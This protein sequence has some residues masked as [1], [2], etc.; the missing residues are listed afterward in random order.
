MRLRTRIGRGGDYP[1]TKSP[2]HIPAK[3][4]L[5]DAMV[6][7]VCRVVGVFATPWLR[8]P[9]GTWHMPRRIVVLKPCCMGDV[10]FTTP[11]L[12][13]IKAAYPASHLTVATSAWCA[14]VVVDNPHVDAVMDVPPQ[15]GVRDLRRVAALLREGGYDTALVPDRSPL[16]GVIV[17]LAGIPRRVGLNSDGRG[18]LYTDRVPVPPDGT[19]H[20]AAL[21]SRLGTAIGAPPL[22]GRGTEYRPPTDD[23]AAMDARIAAAGWQSPLWIIHPGGGVNPGT[24]FPPKRWLPDRFAA[25]A[26]GLLRDHGGTVLL[27]G[28]LTDAD[29][30]AAVRA[31]MHGAAVDLTDTLLFGAWQ[32]LAHRADLY[33]GND[34]GMTHLALAG[35]TPTVA[36]FGPTSSI[37]YGLYGENGMMAVGRVPWSPCWRNGSLACT[38]GTIQCMR[39]VPVSAVRAAADRLWGVAG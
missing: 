6:G 27:L 26:D 18:M 28:T 31:A 16:L 11:L 14:S 2:L 20:E 15:I 29:A 37:Q 9:R 3:Q 32:A 8:P 35:G 19:M 39:S 34:T 4:R 7:A 5:R 12:A 1:A 24:A 17:A 33:I 38:C 25:L 22:A 36:I 21:Y 10:L 23:L 30:V 13:A